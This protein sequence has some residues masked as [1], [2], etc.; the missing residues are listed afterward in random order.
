MP[1]PS[2]IANCKSPVTAITRIEDRLVTM[3]DFETITSR[4]ADPS[5]IHETVANTAGISRGEKRVAIAD[6][7]PTARN[8]IESMM[9][10][11]GYTSLYVFEN[12]EA[13][14]KWL[15]A[16]GNDQQSTSNPIDLVITDVEMPVTDGFHLTRR[17]KQ[18]NRFKQV[19]VLLY[20]SILTP[21]NWKKGQAVQADA[22][23]TK[24]E[25]HRVVSM[26]DDLI[27]NSRHRQP[28]APVVSA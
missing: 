20:S 3:L 2:I 10:E 6:D 14:W 4:L 7:S 15:D 18:D 13:L 17:I 1:V 12:G 27:R 8:A 21:D 26:A 11:S 19:P 23:I 16:Q 24:P 25:L 22:Q 5:V 28:C 9:R